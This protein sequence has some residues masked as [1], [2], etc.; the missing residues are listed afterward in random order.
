MTSDNYGFQVSGNATVNAGAIAAGTGASASGSNSAAAPADLA[1]LRRLLEWLTAELHR[2]PPG[3]PDSAHLAV[4]AESAQREAAQP[5]P[6]KHV[7][8]GLLTALMAGVGD[9]GVIASTVAAVQH[10]ITTLL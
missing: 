1:E 8:S 4:I 9:V 5:Q 3:V 7:L 10:A 6:R 2:G